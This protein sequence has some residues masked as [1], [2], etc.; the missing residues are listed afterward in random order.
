MAL[1]DPL[2]PSGDF[3]V[4]FPLEYSRGGARRKGLPQV[5]VHLTFDEPILENPVSCTVV[6]AYSD[7]TSF[8]VLSYSKREIIAEKLR[9]LLQ[10]QKKWPR[11]RDL[12]DLWR[13]LCRA[14]ERYTWE[15]LEPLFIEKCRIRDV[16]PAKGDLA[17]ENLKEWTRG[18]WKDRLGPMLK[19][20]PDFEV[21]WSEW[22]ATMHKL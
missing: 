1:R 22:T 7:L 3:Q 21:V 9:A 6:P 10:Q 13:I 16:E 14:G 11:P 8:E 4:E 17:S 18:A 19:E 12:Y 20:L 5:K 15:E 2:T